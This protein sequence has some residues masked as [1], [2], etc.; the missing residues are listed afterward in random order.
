MFINI[1][2]ITI[3]LLTLFF[4]TDHAINISLYVCLAFFII[5]FIAASATSVGN[6]SEIQ[7]KGEQ[8]K[9]EIHAKKILND[10]KLIY[11]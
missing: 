8:L 3:H 4:S 2:N 9:H 11:I 1:S 6:L 7:E 5:E 10:R